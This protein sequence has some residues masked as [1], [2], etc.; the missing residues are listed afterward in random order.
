MSA[1]P[2]AVVVSAHVVSTDP[3][4]IT[5]AAE[6]LTRA[7]AGLA[8]EGIEVGLSMSTQTDQEDT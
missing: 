7:I 5:K 4:Q 6:V 8:L 2:A 3:G 1:D